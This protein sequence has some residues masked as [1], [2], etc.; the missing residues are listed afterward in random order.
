MV[1]LLKSSVTMNTLAS[2]V[3]FSPFVSVTPCKWLKGLAANAGHRGRQVSHS[4]VNLGNAF[5]AGRRSRQ[6]TL[7]P[8][9][10]V[11]KSRFFAHIFFVE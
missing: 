4:E 5:C 10:D 6:V 9:T 2:F 7:K 1:V 11:P 8:G 3:S